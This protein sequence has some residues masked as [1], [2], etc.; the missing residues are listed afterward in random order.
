MFLPLIRKFAIIS[1]LINGWLRWYF[2]QRF[3]T[4]IIFHFPFLSINLIYTFWWDILFILICPIR[5]HQN[6]GIFDTKNI[7]DFFISIRVVRDVYFCGDYV[8]SVLLI[9]LVPSWTYLIIITHSELLLLLFRQLL[10]IYSFN[11]KIWFI[12]FILIY[13]IFNL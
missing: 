7:G 2:I 9:I 11:I 3:T 8:F 4:S 10:L 6:G 12:S 1:S 13:L 5:S